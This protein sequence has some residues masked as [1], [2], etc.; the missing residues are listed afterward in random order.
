[1]KNF[2]LREVEAF[3]AIMQHGTITKAADFL[4]ISQPAVS[5]LLGQF[6]E[7]AGFTVFAREKKRLFPTI[8][9]V[10]LFAEVE[11]SFISVREITRVAKDIADLKSG[12]LKIGLL[13]ALGSGVMPQI[14]HHFRQG[15]P[16]IKISVNVRSTKTLVDWAGRNQLDLAVGVSSAFDN[17]TVIVNTLPLVPIVCVMPEDHQLA[18]AHQVTLSDLEPYSIVS[19]LPSDPISILIDQY[20]TAFGIRINSDIETNLASTAITFVQLGSGVAIVDILSYKAANV[21]GLVC[22][23]FLPEMTLSYSIY[24]QKESKS[25]VVAEEFIQ[26]VIAHFADSLQK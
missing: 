7:K 9:A 14:I 4:N 5:K 25:S 21:A 24:R 26:F 16:S 20:S 12:R 2:S 11:R 6:E 13:P 8:E 1:M 19:L 22:R 15:H 10:S 3:A 18:A 17:P 23:P